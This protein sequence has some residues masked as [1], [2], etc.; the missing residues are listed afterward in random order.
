LFFGFTGVAYAPMTVSCPSAFITDISRVQTS[1]F[2]STKLKTR[3]RFTMTKW[4]L[5]DLLLLMTGLVLGFSNALNYD[6]LQLDLNQNMNLWNDLGIAYYDYVIRISC[7]CLLD[8]EEAVSM[9]VRNNAIEDSQLS[10]YP[11]VMELFDTIQIAITE[12]ADAIIVTYD[13]THGYPSFINIDWIEG[14]VDDEITYEIL[15]FEVT[16]AALDAPLDVLSLAQ[17]ALNSAKAIWES[18][19]LNRY[20]FG[21]QRTCFCPPEYTVPLLVQVENNEVTGMV[22]RDGESILPDVAMFVPTIEGIF[23]QIQDAISQNASMINVAYD[24]DYGYPASVYVVYDGRIADGELSIV[25]D[26][27]GPITEWQ[28][29]LDNG[30]ATWAAAGLVTYTYEYQR[31]CECLPEDTALKVVKAVDGIVV[32]VDGLPVE[33]INAIPTIAGLFEQVQAAIDSDA[34]RVVVEYDEELGYPSSIFIDYE[35]LV[36]DEELRVSATL[37]PDVEGET[38]TPTDATSEIPS[39]MPSLVPSGAPSIIPSDAPSLLP[40]DEP[41]HVSSDAVTD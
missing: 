25:V 12:N 4:Y 14:A 39:D 38:P 5:K 20:S 13:S 24:G 11:T 10:G 19:A 1:P 16:S 34:F 29:A 9:Q 26:Y 37:L 6:A 35:E 21:Y 36:A 7:F 18:R 8:D 2:V 31:S 3:D 40:S 27:I 33:S 30:S 32:S 23:D 41:S 22:G 17:D 15:D 28:A